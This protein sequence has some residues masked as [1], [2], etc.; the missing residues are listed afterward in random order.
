MSL[1]NC[2]CGACC[3]LCGHASDCI[4]HDRLP[5]P[6]LDAAIKDPR[7]GSFLEYLLTEGGWAA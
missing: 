1:L 5:A 6:S 7:P 4:R 2:D 3:E